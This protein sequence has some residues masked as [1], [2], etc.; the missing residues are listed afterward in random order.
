MLRQRV[1]A[2]IDLSNLAGLSSEE[3]LRISELAISDLS[4]ISKSDPKDLQALVDRAD[5]RYRVSTLDGV[6]SETA[7]DRA[8]R[9]IEDL[10]RVL[11][12]AP[13]N[14]QVVA[15]RGRT[16]HQF[17]R[18]L[19]EMRRPAGEAFE[20][21]IA[22]LDSVIADSPESDELWE[23]RGQARMYLGREQQRSRRDPSSTW[24]AALADFGEAIRLEPAR[25]KAHR[26]RGRV[27]EWMGK[28]EESVLEFEAAVR[29]APENEWNR[30][31]LARSRAKAGASW[32]ADLEIADARFDAQDYA[33]ARPLLERALSAAS[34]AEES[35]PELRSLLRYVARALA[36]VYALLSQGQDAPGAE[37]A[38]IDPGTAARHRDRAFELLSRAVALGWTDAAEARGL[39][40][41][42]PLRDDPRWT[43]LLEA[44][45]PPDKKK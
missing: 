44:L 13:G 1:E 32:A 2:S 19:H 12:A 11:K 45:A 37:R 31:A 29:L 22:D 7:L 35:D 25:W 40:D 17:A 5:C 24:K 21:A 6:A 36:C 9:A 39:A 20:T 8:R 14:S 18:I 23:V 28:Y 4:E 41:L 34:R 27:F 30:D 33:S 15:R 43:A 3:T 10:D 42:A 38:T 26:D 16:L